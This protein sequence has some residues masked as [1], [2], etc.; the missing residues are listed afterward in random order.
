MYGAC[1]CICMVHATAMAVGLFVGQGCE[2]SEL[3]CLARDDKKLGRRSWSFY[4][5]LIV[6]GP[7]EWLSG[8]SLTF[9]TYGATSDKGDM[10]GMRLDFK[11]AFP[12]KSHGSN[13]KRPRPSA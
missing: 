11:R 12:A 5:V 8:L 9:E 4:I 13:V 10:I 7:D 2:R 1:G 6:V 3:P